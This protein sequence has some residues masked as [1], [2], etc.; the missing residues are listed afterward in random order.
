[1]FAAFEDLWA[2]EHSLSPVP[3]RSSASQPLLVT[4][5]IAVSAPVPSAVPVVVSAASATTVLVHA[6]SS[7][8]SAHHVSGWSLPTC[9]DVIR[10]PCNPRRSRTRPPGVSSPVPDPIPSHAGR[11][12]PS[13]GPRP[14]FHPFLGPIFCWL[15][16]S[17][18]AVGAVAGEFPPLFIVVA[19][20]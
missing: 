19:V 7:S 11:L 4:S 8:S 10:F 13:P 3:V 12:V 15:D 5:P 14:V 1:M 18:V 16:T 17:M 9:L 20:A 6:N 2:S